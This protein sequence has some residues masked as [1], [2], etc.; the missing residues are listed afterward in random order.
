MRSSVLT[1]F[2]R[3]ITAVITVSAV[4]AAQ[5]PAKFPPDSLVNTHVIAH[6]TPVIQVIGTMRNFTFDLGVR[7]QYCHLGTEGQPLT[8]FNFV[9]DE[10]RTKLVARQMMLMVQEINRRLDSLPGRASTGLQVTCNTCHR[11]T[12][13][14]VPLYTLIVE[15]AAAAGSDSAVRAYRG[16]RERYYGRDAYDFGE[17]SLNTAAFRL[18]N[19]KKF[20]EAFAMLRLNE[21]LYPNSSGMYVFRGNINLMKADT[22]AAEAAF[23]EAVRRDPT[24]AEAK[25]RLQTI[26]KQP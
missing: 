8:Q 5:T 15:A 21:E 14:P 10:K 23:R 1:A 13:R 20:D 4:C 2:L 25:G 24:N 11:G 22:A 6:S 17:G 7:C 18:G 9:S 3:V 16:L 19:A 12:N 26:G